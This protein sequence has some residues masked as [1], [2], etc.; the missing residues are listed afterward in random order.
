MPINTKWR[1]RLKTS[2]PYAECVVADKMRLPIFLGFNSSH[3]CYEKIQ[4][5]M[6]AYIL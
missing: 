3:P 6:R 2:W 5:K 1:V 4:G